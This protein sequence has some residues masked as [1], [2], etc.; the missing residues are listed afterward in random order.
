MIKTQTQTKNPIQTQTQNPIQTQTPSTNHSVTNSIPNLGSNSIARQTIL[1][2]EPEFTYKVSKKE[3]ESEFPETELELESKEKNKAKKVEISVDSLSSTFHTVNQSG[4]QTLKV[5]ELVIAG[6]ECNH[7]D[8]TTKE[9]P[10]VSGDM[11][12]ISLNKW[13]NTYHSGYQ[14][15]AVDNPTGNEKLL[16]M[17]VREPEKIKNKGIYGNNNG[18]NALNGWEKNNLYVANY[19]NI[20]GQGPRPN[21]F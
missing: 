9:D 18:S 3:S 15:E 7:L 13:K 6:Q 14:A 20:D 1:I 21:P 10:K 17:S 12:Y 19:I 8:I 16:L 11:D 2:K 5:P 4:Y